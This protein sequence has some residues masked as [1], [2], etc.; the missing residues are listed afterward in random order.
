MPTSGTGKAPKHEG[1]EGTGHPCTG[2]A[3][4][5]GGGDLVS[6]GHDAAYEDR[7]TR[8]RC[9]QDRRTSQRETQSAPSARDFTMNSVTRPMSS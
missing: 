4:P 2:I 5:Q 8:A 7:D 1:D 6:S 3:S 9:E